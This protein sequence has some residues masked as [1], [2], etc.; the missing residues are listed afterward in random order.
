MT[1]QEFQ[2][3]CSDTS[4]G[5]SLLLSYGELE[6]CGKFIGCAEDAIVIEANGRSYVWPR[7]LCRFITTSDAIPSYS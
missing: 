6:V 7:E 4:L 2:K 3:L 1:E 5:D